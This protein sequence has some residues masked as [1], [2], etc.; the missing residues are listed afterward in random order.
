MRRNFD[1]FADRLPGE[2]RDRCP[3]CGA[4]MAPGQA[5]CRVCLA[6]ALEDRWTDRYIE[7][8]LLSGYDG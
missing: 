3:E 7:D 4:P 8:R 6:A 5:L 2:G 1:R